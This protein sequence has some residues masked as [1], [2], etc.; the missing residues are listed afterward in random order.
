MR[1]SLRVR[2]RWLCR[3]QASAIR[4][5]ETKS[6][7]TAL[8]RSKRQL[9]LISDKGQASPSSHRGNEGGY[10]KLAGWAIQTRS[11][12]RT[13]ILAVGVLILLILVLA[14]RPDSAPPTL[15]AGLHTGEQPD[16]ESQVQ[17][18]L[19]A[20]LP[21]GSN[22]QDG[23]PRQVVSV[24]L[25]REELSPFEPLM[26]GSL[27]VRVD[28]RPQHFA[29]ENGRATIVG[30]LEAED[31]RSLRVLDAEGASLFSHLSGAPADGRVSCYGYPGYFLGQDPPVA[32]GAP[33]SLSVYAPT[34]PLSLRRCL[35]PAQAA[36]VQEVP[37]VRGEFSYVR[38][39]ETDDDYYFVR[40]PGFAWLKIFSQDVSPGEVF[41]LHF[42]RS[43]SVVFRG[44]E[45][46]LEREPRVI[47][48][49]G[50]QPAI[51]PEL[52]EVNGRVLDGWRPGKY[53]AFMTPNI[54]ELELSA[55]TE[56]AEFEVVA[57]ETTNVDFVLKEGFERDEAGW[58]YLEGTLHIE[59]WVLVEPWNTEVG[60]RIRIKRLGPEDCLEWEGLRRQKKLLPVY[61]ME[62]VQSKEVGDP[63]WRWSAGRYPAGRYRIHVDP[64]SWFVDVVVKPEETTVV[65][66][67]VPTLA[68]TVIAISAEG[69]D[70]SNLPVILFNLD[71]ANPSRFSKESL[72]LITGE[73]GSL[74]MISPPGRYNAVILWNG[75]V[76][77]QEIDL[78]AGWNSA[79][80]AP[81]VGG[82][83][84]GR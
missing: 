82:S 38:A 63:L 27:Q 26:T 8:H 9:G 77:E 83:R 10:A 34:D 13:T 11:I 14:N 42:E 76:Y 16:V 33:N 30:S 58:G 7:E 37:L 17:S 23:A 65:E 84:H 61:V 57:G 31:W 12:M 19:A 53:K 66:A 50:Y 51:R 39:F 78:H 1:C 2:V 22:R 55:V 71:D 3:A 64:L 45:L 6:R 47:A 81:N 80:P 25:K 56:T 35:Y 46:N 29:V 41:W 5:S 40:R 49:S 48:Q 60:L 24:E 21:E 32:E 59:S 15:P 52:H 75:K 74:Q 67:D 44:P 69:A 73:A 36:D 28:G 4:G 72:Q 79:S 68:R 62:E 20:H 54:S 43:G 18:D 70:A